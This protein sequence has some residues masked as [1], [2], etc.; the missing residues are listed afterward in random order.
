M[1]VWKSWR[2]FSCGDS[3]HLR[4]ISIMSN[5]IG[6]APKRIG[7]CQWLYRIDDFEPTRM[8]STWC[9][10]CK[11]S[12]YGPEEIDPLSV[13]LLVTIQSSPFLKLKHQGYVRLIWSMNVQCRDQRNPRSDSVRDCLIIIAVTWFWSALVRESLVWPVILRGT[14][15]LFNL[16]DW[17]QHYR[18]MN[19]M[20][21]PYLDIVI[22]LTV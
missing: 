16:D 6:T 19:L 11:I 17:I 15:I 20:I 21:H 7:W 14:K 9:Q 22:V 8:T 13:S 1:N 10:S 4:I 2:D 5:W 12:H 3:P 18:D